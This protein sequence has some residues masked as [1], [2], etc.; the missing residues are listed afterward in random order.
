MFSASSFNCR[1]LPF[2]LR[3]FFCRDFY[4]FILYVDHFEIFIFLTL[5]TYA[6]RELSR[7]VSRNKI[8]NSAS[9]R[10]LSR[11]QKK[12]RP[13]STPKKIEELKKS[14]SQTPPRILQKKNNFSPKKLF[15]KDLNNRQTVSYASPCFSW[16]CAFW[17]RWFCY[18]INFIL[19]WNQFKKI[20]KQ[21]FC[22]KNCV[23]I[24]NFVNPSP[25]P[26]WSENF[27]GAKTFL[28][29]TRPELTREDFL[30]P[31]FGQFYKNYAN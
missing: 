5:W 13:L 9:S 18:K 26:R 12:N 3:W 28:F 2:S 11:V 17:Y 29:Y 27:L 7:K 10:N 6:T 31:N 19:N 23:N 21:I 16:F 1:F 20:F 25:P 24:E 30:T 4:I 8:K 14:T 15:T 22:K